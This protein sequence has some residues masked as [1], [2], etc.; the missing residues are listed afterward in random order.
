MENG[1]E[2]YIH[3][4]LTDRLGMKTFFADPYCSWQRGTNEFHNGLIRRYLPKGTDFS[5]VTQA[6]LDDIV[7]EINNRPRK[8]LEYA[9]PLEV[10]DQ[11][12]SDC[13]DSK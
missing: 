13:S 2:N 1:G 9:T 12:L 3:F 8:V 5:T 6:E 4:G 7:W 10:F 11:Y